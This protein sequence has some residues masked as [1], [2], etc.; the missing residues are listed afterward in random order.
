MPLLADR[1]GE[2]VHQWAQRGGKLGGTGGTW[3][4]WLCCLLHH[5]DAAIGLFHPHVVTSA[6]MSLE[7]G[8]GLG[9]GVR[10]PTLGAPQMAQFDP[11]FGSFHLFATTKPGSGT[12]S[13]G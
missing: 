13:P 8:S 6:A 2:G 5:Q 9:A 11:S 12:G 4:P 10:N 7:E 3:I 1:L